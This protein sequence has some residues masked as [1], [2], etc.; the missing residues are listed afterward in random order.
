M[1]PS[2]AYEVFLRN[3]SS[4]LLVPFRFCCE[5]LPKSTNTFCQICK[6]QETESK[7]ESQFHITRKIL[8]TYFI[9]IKIDV[10]FFSE[11]HWNDLGFL[12]KINCQDLGKKS[13]KSKILA[14]NEKNPRSWQEIQDYPRSWQENQ[15]AKHWVFCSRVERWFLRKFSSIIEHWSGHILAEGF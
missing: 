1:V 10:I 12:G 7:N 11:S 9:V 15:D 14:T 4:S 6:M 5:F 8:I 3:V 2:M 13:K